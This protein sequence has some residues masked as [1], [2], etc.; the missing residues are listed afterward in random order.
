MQPNTWVS[1]QVIIV[2]ANATATIA[3]IQPIHFLSQSTEFYNG[4]RP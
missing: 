3:T 4:R 2:I 1:A